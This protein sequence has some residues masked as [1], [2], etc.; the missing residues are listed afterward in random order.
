MCTNAGQCAI[1]SLP[2][3]CSRERCSRSTTSFP[4]I[5]AQLP[6]R[7]SLLHFPHTCARPDTIASARAT[8]ARAPSFPESAPAFHEATRWHGTI[9]DPADVNCLDARMQV[10]CSNI[11][12]WIPPPSV[13]K[14]TKGAATGVTGADPAHLD[15]HILRRQRAK[16]VISADATR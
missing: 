9:L 4:T 14:C 15:F 10:A 7:P 3:L 12:R 13:N 11:N 1:I 6:C 8:K 16:R 2:D 5:S